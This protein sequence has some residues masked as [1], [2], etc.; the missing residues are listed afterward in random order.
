MNCL[1]CKDSELS[2]FKTEYGPILICEKCFGHLYNEPSLFK[3]INKSAWIRFIEESKSN[4]KHRSRILHCPDCKTEMETFQIPRKNILIEIDRCEKC[5]LIWFDKNEIEDLSLKQKS[6]QP[7]H[8][9]SEKKSTIN[10]KVKY[11]EDV[12]EE[13]KSKAILSEL[14][15]MEEAK[16]NRFRAK[17]IDKTLAKVN[18]RIKRNYWL[19]DYLYDIYP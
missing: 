13:E 17:L 12:S 7:E 3:Y 19:Y 4:P 6:A 2:K 5:E 14:Q 11:R 9:P 18:K 10:R 1:V 16:E 15:F 8:N